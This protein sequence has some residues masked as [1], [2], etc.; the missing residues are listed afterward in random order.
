M[1]TFIPKLD[2][3]SHSTFGTVKQNPLAPSASLKKSTAHD[4]AKV[5]SEMTLDTRMTEMESRFADIDSMLRL[6][7]SKSKE[8]PLLAKAVNKC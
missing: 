5:I 4:N 2:T 3:D 6:L 7:V 8:S 1:D